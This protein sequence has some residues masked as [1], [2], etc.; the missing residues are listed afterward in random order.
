MGFQKYLVGY[1]QDRVWMPWDLG[2]R[3]CFE[4]G[5]WLSVMGRRMIN[6]LCGFDPYLGFVYG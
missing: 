4:S 3:Q 2:G 1:T 5:S 6:A